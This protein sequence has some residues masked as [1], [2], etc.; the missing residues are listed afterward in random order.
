MTL[1]H[2][3]NIVKQEECKIYIK[4]PVTL[5]LIVM[6]DIWIGAPHTRTKLNTDHLGAYITFGSCETLACILM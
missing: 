2:E 3:S 1:Y 4:V 5:A 6:L